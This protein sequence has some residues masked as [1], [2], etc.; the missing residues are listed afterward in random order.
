ML[1]QAEK[2]RRPAHRREIRVELQVEAAN[3]RRS[4]AFLHFLFE[5]LKAK[6]VNVPLHPEL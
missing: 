2:R 4:A 3:M 5:I 6:P 1:F